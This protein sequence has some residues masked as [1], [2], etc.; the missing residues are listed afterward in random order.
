MALDPARRRQLHATKLRSLAGEYLDGSIEDVVG[1]DYGALATL[2]DRRVVA[3]AE[4]RPERA[5]GGALASAVR[6]AANEVHIFAAGSGDV[7]ARTPSTR[8]R[9][10]LKQRTRVIRPALI[11]YYAK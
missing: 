8:P 1:N 7:L 11:I 2:S 6:S 5:L 3:L 4:E 10:R 9:R